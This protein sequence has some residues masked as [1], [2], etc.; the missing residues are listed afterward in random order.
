MW[1]DS[2]KK[3]TSTRTYDQ[4]PLESSIKREILDYL[5][6]TTGPFGAKVKFYL[7]NIEDSSNKKLGTYGVIKSAKNFIAAVTEKK[8]PRSLEQLGYVLEKGIL[9]A[10]SLGLGTCWLAGTFKRQE[11]IN[12]IELKEEEELPVITPIGYPRDKRSVVDSFMRFA[13]GSNNRKDFKELF[14]EGSWNNEVNQKDKKYI[15]A[16][17]M[18]RLA[19]SASNKQPWRVLVDNEKF[20]FY[21]ARNKGY[22]EGL[23]YD[24][25]KID[26]GIAMCH[27]ELTMQELGFKGK[28][29]EDNP[30]KDKESC[31]YIISFIIE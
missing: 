12:T 15:Q 27:F 20:H 28:W 5:N 13:A 3:R 21:L 22:G 18:L 29:K 19:P 23:G 8:E 9:Y 16:L 4:R 14:F 31:E 6:S 17:E 24:V 30:K 10:T 2:I 7:V 1:I 11:F 26:I 25:Q